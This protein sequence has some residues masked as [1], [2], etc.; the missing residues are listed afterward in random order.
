MWTKNIPTKKYNQ[1]GSVVIRA[2]KLKTLGIDTNAG[3]Y[4]SEEE[5]IKEANALKR[6]ILYFA[7]KKGY[8]VDLLIGVSKNNPYSGHIET[9]KTGKAG[10]PK[11][12][13]KLDTTFNPDDCPDLHLHMLLTAEPADTVANEIIDYL[14][15]RHK[16]SVCWKKD[17]SDYKDT[18]LEYIEKQALT[19]RTLKYDPDENKEKETPKEDG[20]IF[21]KEE[22]TD[23]SKINR[24]TGNY[25]EYDRFISTYNTGYQLECNKSINILIVFYYIRTYIRVRV[26]PPPWFGGI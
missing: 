4:S 25:V 15:K 7:K 6:H 12:I 3:I 20:I 18:A 14:K 16:K 13:F 8:K 19:T 21:T 17:C 10:R 22:I 23:N 11:K 2:R 9:I 24:I 26:D 1:E 5:A